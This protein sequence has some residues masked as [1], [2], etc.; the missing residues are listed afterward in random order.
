MYNCPKVDSTKAVPPPILPVSET[1][2]AWKEDIPF[3]DFSV[4]RKYRHFFN[5]SDL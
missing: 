2:N 3:F 4:Y 5:L 1:D